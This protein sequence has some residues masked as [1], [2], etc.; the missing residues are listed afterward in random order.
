[1][2]TKS[3]IGGKVWTNVDKAAE[4]AIS[5]EVKYTVEEGAKKTLRT[6]IA[7]EGAKGASYTKKDVL[8]RYERIYGT[9]YKNGTLSGSLKK[10][11]EAGVETGAALGYGLAGQHILGATTAALNSAAHLARTQLSPDM[12]RL[13]GQVE[14]F[15]ARKYQAVYD[16]LLG[17]SD[18]AKLALQ[19]GYK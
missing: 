19:Y 16:K 14:R 12:Q 1:L 11:Y 10:G 9:P 7:D 3:A 13:L 8:D 15:G 17:N 2:K 4:R 6:R 5:N 18:F